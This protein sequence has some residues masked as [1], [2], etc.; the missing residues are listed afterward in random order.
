MHDNKKP[1]CILAFD[2]GTQHIGVAIGQTITHTASPLAA[3]SAKDGV[4][5]WDNIGA[6][7]S[8]WKPDHLLVGLPLNMDGTASDMS[9]RA[10][11]FARRLHGRFNL[12][13]ITWDERLSSFEARG[14]LLARG[15]RNF[16]SGGVDSLSARLI[17]ESW[18]ATQ[19]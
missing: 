17:L 1:A 18:F 7:I 3:I 13:V 6:L 10:E 15:E 8:E 19:I 14:E 4:P 11:K 2:Y 5:N 16:K 12:P 9:Q